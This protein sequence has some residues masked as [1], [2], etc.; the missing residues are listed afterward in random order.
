MKTDPVYERLL[1]ASWRRELI[2]AEEAQLR[3]WLAANPDAQA[4]WEAEGL[5]TESLKRLPSVTVSCNFT[6]RVLDAARRE[7]AAQER[8][9]ASRWKMWHWPARWLPRAA[10]ATLVLGAGLFAYHHVRLD[11]REEAIRRSVVTVSEAQPLASPEVFENFDAI[12]AM[13][14]SSAADVE[15]LKLFQ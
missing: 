13:S 1:E 7:S 10:L 11:G 9:R 3:S 14:Q 15:L 4:E 8:A 12:Q 2:P 5:L 6:A